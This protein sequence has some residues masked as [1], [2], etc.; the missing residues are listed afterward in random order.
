[1]PVHVVGA[2]PRLKGAPA[3]RS[4]SSVSGRGR[5]GAGGEHGE[6]EVVREEDSR[7]E[8]RWRRPK[9]EERIEV[10]EEEGRDKIVQKG[11]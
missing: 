5:G 10:K 6:E 1:M 3:L 7:E 11:K 9:K 8:V 2:G 4:S